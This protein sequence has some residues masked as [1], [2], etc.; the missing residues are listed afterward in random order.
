MYIMIYV[1]TDCQ[2]LFSPRLC[3][4]L[5]RCACMLQWDCA[6]DAWF[7]FV[8]TVRVASCIFLTF[9]YGLMICSF[10]ASSHGAITKDD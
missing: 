9:S 5:E 10:M 6:D 4:N 7:C 8:L 2:Y 3:V 1:I